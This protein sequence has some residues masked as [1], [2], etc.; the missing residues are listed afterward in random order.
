E[1]EA[2]GRPK[3]NRRE[4]EGRSQIE[5][6]RENGRAND[7][8]AR[9]VEVADQ[10]I[11]D[12]ASSQAFDRD[13]AHPAQMSGQNGKECGHKDE[14][15][16]S[17]KSLR[18]RSLHRSRAEPARPEHDH[19]EGQQKRSDAPELQDEVGEISSHDADPVAGSVRSGKDGGA[20][21]RGIE[22]RIGRQ[23]EKK[24]ECGDA[25]QEPDELVQTPVPGGR[26][27]LREKCHGA[28][29]ALPRQDSPAASLRGQSW[30]IMTRSGASHNAG[31]GMGWRV[32]YRPEKDG[33]AQ[34]LLAITAH[35]DV[36][37]FTDRT[38]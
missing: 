35:Q 1:R 19:E 21:Q 12:D 8:C 6:D 7:V 37:Y 32:G 3:F 38:R 31:R 14:Q 24:E 15:P 27:N 17:A 9:N 36:T 18:D 11:T 4:G 25:Q 20:V 29:T 13:R 30:I 28:A 33:S 34:S 26:K 16:D 5:R 23:R 22:R 2:G 10:D